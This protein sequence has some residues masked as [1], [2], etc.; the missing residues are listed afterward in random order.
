MK[1]LRLISA[2]AAQAVAARTAAQLT[3]ATGCE[4][5]AEYGAVGA[6]NSRVVGGEPVD[7]IILTAALIEE[8]PASGHVVRGSRSLQGT[9]GELLSLLPLGRADGVTTE[10]LAYPLRGETL[11]AGSSRG[12]RL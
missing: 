6:M 4:V 5:Q 8:L 11:E 9:P 2:G 3:A 1:R 10:G 12:V 7:V